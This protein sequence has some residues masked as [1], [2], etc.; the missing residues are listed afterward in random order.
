LASE[1]RILVI[2][3]GNPGRRDDGLGPAL[4]AALERLDLPGVTVDSDYQLTVEH[5]AAVAEHDA[6]VFA[7]AAVAG[8]GSVGV[9]PAAEHGDAKRRHG[10]LPFWFQ[11]IVAER[12]AIFSSHSVSP[13]SVLGL[14]EELFGVRTDGYVLAIRG[15]E[16]DTFGE[17][18]SLLARDNLAR[19]V[20][21]LESVIRGRSFRRGAWRRKASPWHPGVAAVA[22]SKGDTR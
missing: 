2:G 8:P 20:E 21:F 6:V 14:A 4:A 5:A 13:A 7:D 17:G 19:A 11:P 9:P 22:A 3:Y 12:P 16:F 15:Y 1:P 10:T 18:L